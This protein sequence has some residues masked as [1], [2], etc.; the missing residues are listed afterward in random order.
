MSRHSERASRALRKLA[1][2]DPAF[3]S[4]SLWVAHED[5]DARPLPAWS[6]GTTI[7]YGPSFETHSLPE[8]MGLAAHHIL[9]VAFRHSTRREAMALRFGAAHDGGL[10]NTAAD[11]V[12]NEALFRAGYVLPRPCVLLTDLLREALGDIAPPDDALARWDAERLYV[13]LMATGDKGRPREAADKART[14]AARQSFEEDLDA[15]AP[16]EGEDAGE[17]QERVTRAMEAGRLAG[18]G[19]GVIGHRLADLPETRVPWETVLRRLVT[20]AVT[21]LPRQSWRRPTGR[22]LALD[23]AGQALPF[24]PATARTARAPRVAIGID[25]SSSVDATRLALFAAQVAGIAR[26]T[27]AETHVLVFDET[28]RDRQVMRAGTW[29]R[30]VTQ[31]AFTRDGGT[32]FAP[33]LAEADRLDP[34]VIVMLTDLDAPLPPRPR[35]PVIWAVPEAPRAAPAWGRVVSLAR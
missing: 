5:S 27:G 12:L 35:A 3:A 21:N 19:I 6:D 28:V 29:E 9:H 15:G 11:A 7:R 26:R 34:A 17:W 31:L 24:E 1:E 10:F 25:S 14:F 2:T 32:D 13:S 8:Q 16:D 23:A 4:L 18:R 30:A 20:K 22:W 33:V